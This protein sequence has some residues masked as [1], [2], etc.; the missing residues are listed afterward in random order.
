MNKAETILRTNG[1][2]LALAC[3]FLPI[4]IGL[5]QLFTYLA[6]VLWVSGCVLDRRKAFVWT[7][8]LPWA[9]L[10][11]LVVAIGILTGERAER[12]LHKAHR[13]LLLLLLVAVPATLSRDPRW[14]K[15]WFLAFIVGA[16]CLAAYDLIRIPLAWRAAVAQI[17]S[18]LDPQ[19][20]RE[21]VAFALY[22]QGNMRDPQFYLVALCMLLP[23][24][25]VVK[26]QKTRWVLLAAAVVIGLSFLLHNKRGAWLAFGCV[27]IAYTLCARRWKLILVLGAVALSALLVPQVRQRIANLSDEFDA[28]HGG[29]L[30]LW[31]EAFPPFMAD[32]PWGVGYLAVKHEDFL[33]Y[34]S[35]VSF[36]V[37]ITFTTT[38]SRLRRSWVGWGLRYGWPG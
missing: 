23:V 35:D 11:V 29:R 9:L 1:W 26:D 32:H 34:T 4:S 25:F 18:D 6:V 17:A 38:C 2:V 7:P 36:T 5:V 27:A 19:A 28:N 31:R 3:F 37:K 15:K 8:L 12:S 10:F 33:A 20:Y 22:D 21:A 13:L 16:C 24:F 30:E 14:L